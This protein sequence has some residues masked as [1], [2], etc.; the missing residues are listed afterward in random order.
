MGSKNKIA[1]RLFEKMLEIKPK[2]K[3]FFDL[4]GGGGAMSF[5]ALQLGLK[6][7]YNEKQKGL[8]DLLSYIL[9]AKKGK[10]GIFPDDFYEFITR[11]Q[12]KILKDEN[13]LK[14]QFARICY[15]FGNNQK[16][17]SFGNTENLKRL[18]HNIVVF[19]CKESL[20][21]F[22]QLTK[23]N[24]VLSDAKTWNERRLHFIRQF[25]RERRDK[26]EE[27]LE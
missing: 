15:S 23:S 5:F 13:S 16:N 3:Y 6:V 8:V 27:F 1:K 19:Q 26:G 14:G 4:F 12:F 18:G 11:E 9:N 21:K 2:A 20:S 17:Y 25:S 7:H 24:F 22:N 10:F